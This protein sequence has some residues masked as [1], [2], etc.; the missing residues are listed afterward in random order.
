MKKIMKKIG[1]REF[2]GRCVNVY[3]DYLDGL[4]AGRPYVRVSK[5]IG[6][7]TIPWK[8]RVDLSELKKC[9]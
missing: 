9:K 7:K 2:K 1:R 4:K 6:R 8:K 5:K 3:R